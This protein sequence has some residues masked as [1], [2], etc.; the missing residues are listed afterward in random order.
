M[1]QDDE[2]VYFDKETGEFLS[3]NDLRYEY[4]SWKRHS[5][6]VGKTFE[7]FINKLTT[8]DGPCENLNKKTNERS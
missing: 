3:L 5:I 6:D 8:N 7:D 1:N 2:K 4:Q